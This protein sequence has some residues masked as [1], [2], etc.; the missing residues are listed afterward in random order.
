MSSRAISRILMVLALIAAGHTFKPISSRTVF[1]QVLSAAESLSF[2]LPDFAE[3]RI[4]QASYLASA[5]TE[6]DRRADEGSQPQSQVTMAAIVGPSE[7]TQLSPGARCDQSPNHGV[8]TLARKTR[9]KQ[10]QPIAR[11]P[12]ALPLEKALAFNFVPAEINLTSIPV[13]RA[14]GRYLPQ[15]MV[16]MPIRL[17]AMLPARFV[18]RSDCETIVADE[19]KL[20]Q[21]EARREEAPREAP[22]EEGPNEE[23]FFLVLEVWDLEMATEMRE[24]AGNQPPV[25]APSPKNCEVAVPEAMMPPPIQIPKD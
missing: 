6:S 8:P 3:V 14:G 2:V 7:G 5:F 21:T 13:T 22:R 10:L 17:K 18:M 1:E 12:R 16:F 20:A 11:L 23:D 19:T 25:P 9:V 15:R 4:A 24:R